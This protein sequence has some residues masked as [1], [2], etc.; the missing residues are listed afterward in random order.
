MKVILFVRWPI[1]GIRTYIRYIY[2]N[3]AFSSVEFTLIAPELSDS[4]YFYNA[5]EGKS[6]KYIPTENSPQSL[7]RAFLSEIRSKHYDLVHSHGF[8]SATLGAPVAKYY[9]VPHLLTSHD[10][11]FENQFS[12]LKGTIKRKLTEKTLQMV[13]LI[14]TVSMDGKRNLQEFYPT[15]RPEG[16]R[17]IL[18]GIDSEMFREVLT[19]DLKG[20]LGLPGDT[21][22]VG[23]FGRFMSQKGF[24]DL[25]KAVIL[26]N[27]N[28]GRPVHVVSFGWGGFIREEQQAI[29]EQGLTEYFHFLP[30]TDDM[31][32]S[33]RGV[34]CVAMPS[35]WE[36]CPLLPMEALS[37]GV[38]LIASD[39]IGLREVVADT[40]AMVFAAGNPEALA[41]RLEEF[42]TRESE[43]TRT[44]ANFRETALDRFSVTNTVRA[45]AEMYQ[46]VAIQ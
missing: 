45:T 8:L 14:H 28:Q 36:A 27:H 2:S 3:P 9:K 22:L 43:L 25:V 19:R 17:A 20:E 21:L 46:E 37:V 30:H 18:N 15:L 10:V 7:F 24:K 35:L 16:I 41:A 44:F 32:A 6:F 42:M 11:L 4:S 12:G 5:F 39:C 34:D 31:A 29:D 23:F 40:P 38:P 1:G 13:D 33:L 26:L